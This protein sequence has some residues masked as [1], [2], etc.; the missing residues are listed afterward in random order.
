MRSLLNS[1]INLSA[2]FSTA[3]K[4]L[5]DKKQKYNRHWILSGSCEYFRLAS[6]MW[7][8]GD[9]GALTIFL[10]LPPFNCDLLFTSC[11]SK[12]SESGYKR[13][14]EGRLVDRPTQLICIW[15]FICCWCCCVTIQYVCT[16]LI[17]PCLKGFQWK[18][19]LV[20]FEN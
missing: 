3:R 6:G 7:E 19:L 14:L 15:R 20:A 13:K 17:S 1:K 16:N 8:M 9:G 4:F 11:H 10:S 5:A 18:W 12:C 2:I